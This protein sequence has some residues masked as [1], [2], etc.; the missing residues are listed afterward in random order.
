MDK[1]ENM[2]T[3]EIIEILYWIRGRRA[4]RRDCRKSDP[5]NAAEEDRVELSCF[6]EL[7]ARGVKSW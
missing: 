6:A 4:Y 7:F 3:D 5:V 2:S 1:I